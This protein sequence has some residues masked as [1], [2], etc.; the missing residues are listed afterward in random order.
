MVGHV[1]ALEDRMNDV[2]RWLVDKEPDKGKEKEKEKE[3]DSESLRHA[4]PTDNVIQ[5]EAVELQGRLGEL[6]WE[7]ANIAVAP[8]N[9]SAGRIMQAAA[10]SML[11]APHSA[12]SIVTHSHPTSFIVTHLTGSPSGPSTPIR[13][14]KLSS[15]TA[16]ES[17]SPP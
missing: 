4:S 14:L 8:N 13:H 11:V 6:G 3:S 12:F 2:E 17:T 10:V 9:L 5:E 7:M 16:R 1:R 15:T